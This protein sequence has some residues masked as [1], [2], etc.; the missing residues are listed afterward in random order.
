M[1][2][3]IAK[4]ERSAKGLGVGPGERG[5]AREN[6]LGGG[7]RLFLEGNQGMAQKGEDAGRR[8]RFRSAKLAF[9]LA[10]EDE[11]LTE[12]E[13][14]GTHIVLDLHAMEIHGDFD[15]VDEV[16]PI[17]DAAVFLHVEQLDG[18]DIG[19]LAQLFG[20]EK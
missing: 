3:A 19:G 6:F 16:G 20:S 14:Q 11:M 8:F 17:E 9:F 12:L 2:M 4:L 5:D 1:S 10:G 13:E 18:E 15:V 7:W